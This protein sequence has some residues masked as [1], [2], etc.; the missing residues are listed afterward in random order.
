MLTWKTEP[1]EGSGMDA[2]RVDD[3]ESRYFSF[4]LNRQ[5]RYLDF[6]EKELERSRTETEA[7]V[8]LSLLRGTRRRLNK[9]EDE[10]L[11]SCETRAED[12]H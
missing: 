8:V 4:R 12:L 10:F 5:N 2:P 1:M 11:L 3:V 9:L 7:R 6:L